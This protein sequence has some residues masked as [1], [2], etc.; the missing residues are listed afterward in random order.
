MKVLLKILREKIH[1]NRFLR[2]IGNLLTESYTAATMD[3]H[4]RNCLT[5]EPRETES[6]HAW[7]GGGPLEKYS[8]GQLAGGLSYGL[9]DSG[10]VGQKPT[11][12]RR[13]GLC[14]RSLFLDSSG[15][16]VL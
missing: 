2:L 8:E 5:G 16:L 1:D 9:S 4:S 11:S 6:G 3:L 10:R 12:A 7:F 14:G 15:S 13:Q